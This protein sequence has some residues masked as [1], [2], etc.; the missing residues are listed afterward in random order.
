[1]EKDPTK[2]EIASSD[3]G[4]AESRETLRLEWGK[5]FGQMTWYEAK[6]KLDELNKS[7][8][9]GEKPWRF[10]DESEI[11]SQHISAPSFFSKDK[12][13]WSDE[14]DSS[15]F[16]EIAKSIYTGSKNLAGQVG[17]AG[18]SDTGFFRPVR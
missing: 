3:S 1:M 13:Y 15:Q 11:I 16:S 10:P 6:E 4:T 12:N 8:K 5:D 17:E 9:K 14:F 2:N 18:K 7:L